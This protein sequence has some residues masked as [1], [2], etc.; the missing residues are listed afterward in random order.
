MKKIITI[1]LSIFILISCKETEESQKLLEVQNKSI[2]ID[3]LISEFHD[4]SSE[5][6]TVVA[7]RGDWR[8]APENSIQ[9]IKNCIDMGVD[10]VEIDIRET[11][12]GQLVLM[13]D[14]TVDRTTTGTGKVSELTWEYLQLLTLRDGI[15]HPT[16]HKIPTLEEA[17]KVCKG[18][19]LVNLDK[20]YDIFDKCFKVAEQTGTLKQIVIKGN[21]TKKEVNQ[22]FGDYLKKVD[23][24][25]IVRLYNSNA[26][27]IV[28]EYLQ[29]KHSIPVAFEFT[30][31]QDTI[32]LIREF[33]NIRDQGA[34]VWVNSLWP[35]HNSGHDDEKASLD[36]SAYDWF[37]NNHINIIQTDRPGLLIDYLQKKG[38]HR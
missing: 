16:F 11:K 24:M 31:P 22:Q 6:I 4:S 32:K 29:D 23:F 26:K 33:K 25:P 8:H 38:L 5:Y 20:S 12:D 3:S 18:K 30:V 19:I 21:K 34:S 28:Y 36:P 9:A 14:E 17:L 1:L 15:G 37:V 27:E 2:N 35:Q 10:M 13:H 7:H